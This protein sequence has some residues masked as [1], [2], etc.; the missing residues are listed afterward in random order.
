MR[1]VSGADTRAADSRAT[2]PDAKQN[3]DLVLGDAHGSGDLRQTNGGWYWLAGNP[4]QKRPFEP[5]DPSDVS[6][7]CSIP[8]NC[9]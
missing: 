2:R 8:G 5:V 9:I 3:G 1:L 7:Y 6:Y 4:Q